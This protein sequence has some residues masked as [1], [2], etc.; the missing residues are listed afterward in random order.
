M[1]GMAQMK[2]KSGMKTE[3]FQKAGG[4]H[5]CSYATFL[6]YQHELAAALYDSLIKYAK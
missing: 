5:G 4:F 6:E 3:G 2:N 1:Q